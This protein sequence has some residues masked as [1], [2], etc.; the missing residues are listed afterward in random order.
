MDA[1]PGLG[2]EPLPAM[3]PLVADRLPFLTH[4]GW[5]S[6]PGVHTAREDRPRARVP[7]AV[8]TM[9]LMAFVA[10]WGL[11]LAFSAVLLEQ[12]GF[13]VLAA[14]IL[15]AGGALAADGTM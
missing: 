12:Y 14:T 11:A 9:D 5:L 2:V 1:V 15:V 6:Q 13:P 7:P 4:P 8:G 10:H 3:R